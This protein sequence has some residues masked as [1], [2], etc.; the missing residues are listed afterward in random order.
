LVR[1]YGVSCANNE[2]ALVCLE[3]P[4]ISVLEVACNP[5]D[6]SILDELLARA[7][8]QQVTI[9]ARAP[10]AQGRLLR[11]PRL[12]QFVQQ[13]PGR[14]LAQTALQAVMQ[15][16]GVGVVLAGMTTRSHLVENVAAGTAPR[17]SPDEIGMLRDLASVL[18]G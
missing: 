4:G 12:Q 18:K 2:D 17:L 9:V 10:F 11:D 15:L 13:H 6:S 1:H 5:F 8:R 16:P 14:S 3:R 7:V